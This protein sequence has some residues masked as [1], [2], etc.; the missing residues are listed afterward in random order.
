MS[1]ARTDTQASFRSPPKSVNF[2]ISSI[3]S[4]TV[5]SVPL[6]QSV[7]SPS[8]DPA[9]PNTLP[10]PYIP[11]AVV[12]QNIYRSPRGTGIAESFAHL[13]PD[14]AETTEFLI[15]H[16]ARTCG[17]W[18]TMADAG[19][20]FTTTIPHLARTSQILMKAI[21]ALAARHLSGTSC[22]DS[23]LAERYHEECISLLIPALNDPSVTADE[24]MLAALVILRLY[25]HLQFSDLFQ[26]HHLSG[27]SALVRSV[28]GNTIPDCSHG[29]QEASFWGYFRQCLYVACVN[30]EPLKFDISIY[31]IEMRLST[32]CTVTLPSAE[33]ESTWCKWITWILAEVVEFC[34]GPQ[35]PLMTLEEAQSSWRELVSKVDMWE[36]NKPSSFQSIAFL[37]RDPGKHRLFPLRWFGN[38]WHALANM[39][40]F[41]ARILLDVHDPLMRNISMGQFGFRRA[42]KELELKVLE[43][44]RALCGICLANPGNVPTIITLSHAI[45]SFAS[46]LE[47]VEERWMLIGMLQSSEREESWPTKWIV[48]ALL[49]EW[50]MTA[51]TLEAG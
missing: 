42:R 35:G 44:A 34:F 47:D 33:E 16:Y 23:S 7:V 28:M 15:Q 49:E 26:G 3:I 27:T 12:L 25:E 1:T 11:A 4:P 18:F 31:Q 5:Q 2:T 51:S 46:F 24:T 38:E 20:H 39:Y 9:D 41:T 14:S 17:K 13:S 21:C 6:P 30:C 36:C 50:D 43:S 37:D 48:K 10:S 29:L 8:H 45:F 32:P 19:R 40:S 22:Y